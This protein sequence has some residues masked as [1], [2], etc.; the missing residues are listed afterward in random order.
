[1]TLKRSLCKSYAQLCTIY[2]HEKYRKTMNKT[3]LFLSYSY[4]AQYY[5][6]D[7]I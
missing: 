6:Y 2:A 3:L 7:I 1:M 4:C 5:Y